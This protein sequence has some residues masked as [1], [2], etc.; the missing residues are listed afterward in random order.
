MSTTRTLI[1]SIILTAMLLATATE[2][3]PSVLAGGSSEVT[4]STTET[5]SHD[6]ARETPS[7]ISDLPH[8]MDL[9]GATVYFV[10]L[11]RLMDVMWALDQMSD[12][13]LSIPHVNIVLREDCSV[14]GS[15]WTDSEGRYWIKNCAG[16]RTLLHELAHVWDSENLTD[17]D[18]AALLELRGLEHWGGVEWE[19][20]GGEHLAE[21][22]AWALDERTSPAYRIEQN[23]YEELGA[24]YLLAT[25][26]TDAP[27]YERIPNLAER[28]L[29]LLDEL[30]SDAGSN[31]NQILDHGDELGAGDTIG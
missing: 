12:A 23:S 11:Q 29:R 3:Q 15:K 13:G 26:S 2:A 5:L 31:D 24:M 16:R 25:G 4:T 6:E 17:R 8:R 10:R 20:C 19:H 21:S 1:T 27:I 18:R 14:A 30:Q 28:S 9:P 7:S 22:I